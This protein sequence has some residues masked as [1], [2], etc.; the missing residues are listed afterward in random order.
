MLGNHC[1]KTWSST[2]GAVAL[3][4]AEAEFNAMVVGVTRAKGLA[5]LARELGF[6]YLGVVVNLGTDSSAAKSFVNRRGF[7]RMR[8]IEIRELWLQKEVNEGKVK[9]FKLA[10]DLNPADLMTKALGLEEVRIR[11]RNLGIRLYPESGK[12]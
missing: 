10:G 7:G 4:S 5:S 12:G 8:H 3:S 11:L 2:Q 9:V 1:I 6:V